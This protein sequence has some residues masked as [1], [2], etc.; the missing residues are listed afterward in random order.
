[1][2]SGTSGDTVHATAPSATASDGGRASSN[3]RASHQ[4]HIFRVRVSTGDAAGA[5]TDSRIFLTLI[6]VAGHS[7]DIELLQS[8]TGGDKF[9]RGNTDEFALRIAQEIGDITR[10][11]L[12]SDASA[13]GSDWLVSR[14]TIVNCQNNNQYTFD[15][16]DCWIRDTI[17]HEFICSE[18]IKRDLQLENVANNSGLLLTA[19]L[20][21]SGEHAPH[22]IAG[23]QSL[24]LINF[25]WSCMCDCHI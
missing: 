21:I 10:I 13:L 9:E 11:V 8:L 7:P 14:V 1:M 4:F 18:R 22:F 6:G 5:G 17:P 2:D 19:R 25:S 12:R 24:M 15:C 23:R 20:P 16:K 3:V